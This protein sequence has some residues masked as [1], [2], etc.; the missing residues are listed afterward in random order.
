MTRTALSVPL[1]GTSLAEHAAVYAR[2]TAHGYSDLWSSETSVV[3]GLTPLALGAALA[4]GL[5][6]GT[7]IL[8]AYT[9]GPALLAMS[10]AGL[11]Q[12]APG[13]F[14]AGIGASSPAI[15][16]AWN[17]I[18]FERPWY[19]VRDVVRF[20]REALAGEKVT[21]EGDTFSV[22]GFRLGAELEQ[23]PPIYV[24][25]LRVGMLKL[26]A[27][28]GDGVILNWL[29]AEDVRDVVEPIVHEHG[30]GKELVARIF[31]CPSE[32]IE[33]VRAAARRHVTAYLTVP[34]YAAYQ[35]WLGRGDRLRPMWDA[36][37]AGDRK[38]ALAEVSDDLIDELFVHGSPEECW[39]HLQRYR[40]AGIDT[41]VV[42]LMPWGL[43]AVEG[44][45]G[46]GAVP[47]VP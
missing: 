18:A 12:A 9:R 34:G 29:S 43:T 31:V 10:I 38:Q 4:P 11:A 3:D 24:A 2:A 39:A 17:D 21:Y 15:V 36:W 40:E 28:E 16:D 22:R 47:T 33:T 5:R 19:R 41:P 7:A 14:V 42:E 32:D 27:R 37:A 23:P 44:V 8:P 26:A 25:A 13:R 35:E 46:L 20:L 30:P 45:E 6:L 1:Q